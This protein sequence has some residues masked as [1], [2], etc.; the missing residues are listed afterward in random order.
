M[1][2]I[3]GAAGTLWHMNFKINADTRSFNFKTHLVGTD[4]VGVLLPKC[5]LMAA[6]Y[7]SIMP[8][9]AEIMFATLTNDDSV[10]DSR[11]IRDAIGPGTYQATGSPAPASVF[12]AQRVAGLVRFENTEGQAMQIK[13]NP[14]PDDQVA[15][16]AFVNAVTDVVGTPVTDPGA[17]GAADAWAA[18]MNKLMKSIAYNCV[19]LKSR[20]LSGGRFTYAA[21]ANAFLLRPAVKKGGRVFA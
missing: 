6:L 13:V 9:D 7:K 12:D 20:R 14:I 8:K 3:T 15:D 2:Y 5:V 10:R 17:P 19:Y 21:F 16:N 4:P 1:A 18:N 11:F